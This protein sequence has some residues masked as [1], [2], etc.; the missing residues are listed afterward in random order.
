MV[1]KWN[2]IIFPIGL[3][4][5]VTN[6]LP[7]QKEFGITGNWGIS[8]IHTYGSTAKN[9]A[10]KSALSGSIGSYYTQNM[11][12]NNFLKL[13]LLIVQI[14][15][16]EGD[17]SSLEQQQFSSAGKI[18]RTGGI[19]HLTYL[20][21]SLAYLNQKNKLFWN[22][23]LQP[24][25]LLRSRGEKISVSGNSNG[26]RYTPIQVGKYVT[27]KVVF[28]AKAGLSYYLEDNIT[29]KTDLFYSI[30]TIDRRN[31]ANEAYILQWTLG[32]NYAIFRS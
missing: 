12:K 32:V 31:S 24:M 14:E 3:I 18:I 27:P 2:K 20:G 6:I 10:Y 11:G 22:V 1:I 23:G 16:R 9:Y 15:G 8:K 5:L 13:E 29:L 4:L 7:A 30:S 21:L 19:D 26:L 28:G 25:L 17:L